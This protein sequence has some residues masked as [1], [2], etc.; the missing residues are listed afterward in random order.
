MIF[1]RFSFVEYAGKSAT[2]ADVDGELLWDDIIKCARRQPDGDFWVDGTIG[3]H[4]KWRYR[5]HKE[6]GADYLDIVPLELEVTPT[7]SKSAFDS[8]AH[9]VGEAIRISLMDVPI[10]G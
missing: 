9:G 1:D 10:D 4:E 2:G 3:K 8:A 5:I 6:S 7:N